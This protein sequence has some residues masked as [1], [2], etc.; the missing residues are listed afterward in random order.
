ML[1]MQM[2]LGFGISLDND[3][4]TG[5]GCQIAKLNTMVNGWNLR[6]RTPIT[7]ICGGELD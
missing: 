2:V 7:F 4:H 3:P 6:I 5:S 1:L